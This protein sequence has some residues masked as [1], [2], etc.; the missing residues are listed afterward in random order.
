MTDHVIHHDPAV[1]A[2][3][4]REVRRALTE[5]AEA[6]AKWQ[7]MHQ[8]VVDGSSDDAVVLRAY[9]FA[10]AYGRAARTVRDRIPPP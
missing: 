2:I 1:V 3:V 4:E 6:F 7:E 10:S 5:A 9:C 8:R